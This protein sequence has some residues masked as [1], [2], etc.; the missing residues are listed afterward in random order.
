MFRYFQATTTVTH[1]K[2]RGGSA[3][4]PEP[5]NVS[6]WNISF[7]IKKILKNLIQHFTVYL[8]VQKNISN[9][10]LLVVCINIT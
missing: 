2:F 8:S 4:T 3:A 7:G 5:K 1:L 9:S 10:F 6:Y